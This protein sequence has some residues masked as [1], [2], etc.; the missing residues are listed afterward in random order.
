MTLGEYFNLHKNEVHF[1]ERKEAGSSGSSMTKQIGGALQ[2]AQDLLGRL[3]ELGLFLVPVGELEGWWRG[4]PTSKG[5]WYLPAI[6]LAAESPDS[7]PEVASF[8]G[9]VCG[10]FGYRVS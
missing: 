8:V 1:R 2:T 5:E 10:W 4:G 7:L 6:K 3:R 9:K